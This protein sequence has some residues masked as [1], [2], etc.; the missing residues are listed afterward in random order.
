MLPFADRKGLGL[1]LAA[2]AP[3]ALMLTLLLAAAG[4]SWAEASAA[5][6]PLGFLYA[7]ICIPAFYL[8]RSLPLE[9][10]R[11]ALIIVTFLL[12]AVAANELWLLIGNAWTGL[13]ARTS[14]LQGI[15][16]R[17][18][19]QRPLITGLGMLFF[20]LASAAHYLTTSLEDSREAERKAYRL[21]IMAREA[22][23]KALRFQINPHFLFNSLNSIAALAGSDPQG[24]RRMCILLGGF[25]RQS[26][27]FGADDKIPLEEEVALIKDY[28]EIER[29]RR[30]SSLRY[31]F[32]IDS[33]ALA[34]LV[35]ALI[36]QP[37][38]ENAVRHGIA[39][40]LKGG[41]VEVRGSCSEGR[42]RLSIQNPY[43]P[44]ASRSTGT[45]V[46]LRTVEKRLENLYP[47]NA[48]VRIRDQDRQFRVDLS[49]PAEYA[50]RSSAEDAADKPA[51]GS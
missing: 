10:S 32:S 7:F 6:L 29:V 50:A 31:R 11:R 25:F 12:A 8:C 47:R 48:R 4:L 9:G 21:Q 43:D 38:V 27:R 51:K 16:E 14:L 44:Q 40:L 15:D 41:T 26:L 37:L 46:G 34:A 24:S 19:G 39:H 5:G 30:S 33:E 1:Y 13:L 18:E 23:L 49:I 22:E 35:P 17:F 45:G 36:L 3:L 20:L 28:L 42:L 2:W